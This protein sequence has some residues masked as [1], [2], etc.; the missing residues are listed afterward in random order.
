MMKQNSEL[1]RSDWITDN[2]DDTFGHHLSENMA[3]LLSIFNFLPQ[4]QWPYLQA[5][6]KRGWYSVSLQE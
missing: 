6:I 5:T 4:D 2:S 1:Y 3:E